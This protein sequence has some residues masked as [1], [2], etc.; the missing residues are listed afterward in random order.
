M[1]KLCLILLM[2]S[3]ACTNSS[4]PPP[5][6]PK[7]VALSSCATGWWVQDLGSL[8]A[9]C[10]A[11]CKLAPSTPECTAEDCWESTVVG[12]LANG[13][14]IESF[15]AYSAQR[16]TFSNTNPAS[17]R[18]YSVT[19]DAIQLTDPKGTLP[20]KCYDGT[21]LDFTSA[22]YT[23]VARDWSAALDRMVAS[24][25]MSWSGVPIKP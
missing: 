5:A 3:A 10:P 16:G 11:T 2:M 19:A 18:S 21:K 25:T 23:P 24:G 20:A 17:K 7:I 9:K 13:V 6:Q 4:A 8:S 1:R 14:E 22:V 15:V 12:Y